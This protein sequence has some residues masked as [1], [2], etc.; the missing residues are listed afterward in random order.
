LGLK[1]GETM[2]ILKIE[3]LS[4]NFVGITALYEVNL[5]VYEGEILTVIG[6]N[7]SG[8]TSLLNCI[9]RFYTPTLGN[10][11]FKGKEITSLKPYKVTRLGIA[12]TFQNIALFKGMTVLENIK[13]GRHIHMKSGA[14]SGAFYL[15]K[16]FHEEMEHRKFIEEEIVDLLELEDIR[17]EVVHTLPYGFLKKVEL[18]RA[19][20]MQPEL[21]LLD[22]PTGGMN[23]E[24]ID[25]IVRYILDIKDFWKMTIL[26]VEHNMEVI[27]DI[28]DRIYVMNFGRVLASGS[29]DEIQSHPEVI[30]AYLGDDVLEA[31]EPRR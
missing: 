20:A 9:N 25:D 13:A 4:L 23:L 15:G 17:D 29:I 8:K 18:A 5:S 6:P 26:L 27:Q 21:L 16:A 31:G 19:L 28:S 24:E 12:R 10:I 3:R 2:E 7:G 30:K 11:F 14:L 22:E 1:T